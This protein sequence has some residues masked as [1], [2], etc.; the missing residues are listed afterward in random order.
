MEHIH[1]NHATYHLYFKDDEHYVRLALFNKNGFH[2]RFVMPI[3]C[4]NR[5]FK[6]YINTSTKS[7]SKT[8]CA[9]VGE[10][11]LKRT[12]NC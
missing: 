6:S 11:D 5:Q 4:C 7:S 2:L 3:L 10:R 9:N 12:G 1:S 8:A